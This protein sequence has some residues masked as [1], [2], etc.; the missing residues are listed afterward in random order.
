MKI[1]DQTPFFNNETGEISFL[2]RGKAMLKYG[3]SWFK[4]VEAQ[5]QVLTVLDNVLDRN[6]TLLRNVSPPGLETSFHFILVGPA[7]V[8]VMYVTPLTGI[9]RAKGDQWGT[10]TRNTF[11]N[12]KPNLLTRTEHMARAIQVF[13]QR[14]GY[15]STTTVDAILLCSNPSVH[16]DSIRPIIR[17]VM[18]DALERFAISIMQARVVFSPESVQDVIERIL[19]PPEPAPPEPAE[20]LAAAVPETLASAQ[21]EG[22]VVPAFAFPESQAPAW[23]NEPAPLPISGTQTR[24]QV[25]RRMGLNK[26]QRSFLIVLFVIWCLLITAFVF[27]VIKDQWSFLLSLLP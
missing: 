9:F 17:V 20:T 25:P 11:K 14:Q 12:E 22:P 16:V 1:I 21:A 26:K 3:A 23:S 8:F 10:I 13:L 27:L 4:E 15:P 19:N 24:S 5:K 6:Y 18:R 7:G 2:D